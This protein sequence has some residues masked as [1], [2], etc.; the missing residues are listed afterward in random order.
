MPQLIVQMTLGLGG[1]ILFESTLSFL[2][3]GVPLT[4]A[5]WG[6]MISKA[7]RPEILNGFFNLW[8]PAGFLIILAV[9][10]F[11][12]VG[13]GLRDALDPRMKK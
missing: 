5:S 4:Q 11:N 2:G 9:L 6:G 8:G 1:I 7:S 10:A 13:D 12:F 3:L